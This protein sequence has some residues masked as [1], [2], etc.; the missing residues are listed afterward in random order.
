MSVAARILRTVERFFR[1][2]RYWH[3]GHYRWRVA[4]YLARRP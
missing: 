2:L 1:A 4:W 3:C